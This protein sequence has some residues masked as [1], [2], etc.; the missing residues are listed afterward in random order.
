MK[1]SS[2]L[3]TALYYLHAV[4]S[5]GIATLYDMAMHVVALRSF[6]RNKLKKVCISKCQAQRELPT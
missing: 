6:M 4:V 1:I 3:A 2:V 5:N